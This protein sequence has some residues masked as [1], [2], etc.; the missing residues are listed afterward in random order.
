MLK[1][2]TFENIVGKGE[3]AGNQHFLLLPSM[4][5][6]LLETSFNPH[7]ICRLQMPTIWTCLKFCRL[8]M[9]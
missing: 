2:G 7:L 3:N 6:P 4:L 1:T 9:G 5:S 8:V